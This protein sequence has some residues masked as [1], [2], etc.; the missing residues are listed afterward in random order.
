MRMIW[1]CAVLGGVVGA[2]VVAVKSLQSDEPND[3]V[4]SKMARTAAGGAVAGGAV[5][6]MLD[7]RAKRK[8]AKKRRLPPGLTATGLLETAV[9]AAEL[10][11]PHVGR[12]AERTR[13][14]AHRA[15]EAARP[16]LE[17]AADV[18]RVQ[19][20][21]IAE[22]ARPRLAELAESAKP[23]LAELAERIDAPTVVVV[24]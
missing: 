6:L 23:R 19:A 18:A 16:Q 1:K 5:G 10:A 24:R 3:V 4:A 11:Q 15:A 22:A 20:H 17:H 21:Q 2:V 9:K 14:A 8:A 12:A 7:G 13:G